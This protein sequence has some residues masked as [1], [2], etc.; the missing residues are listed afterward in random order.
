MVTIT[1]DGHSLDA[2]ER[3][4][5]SSFDENGRYV[6]PTPINDHGSMFAPEY[7]KRMGI[8]L[9]GNDTQVTHFKKMCTMSFYL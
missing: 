9:F 6:D 5:F 1:P 2:W 4:T 8:F 7:L 3:G